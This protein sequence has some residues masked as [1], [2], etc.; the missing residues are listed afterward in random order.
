MVAPNGARKNKEDHSAIPLTIDELVSTA[1]A[2]FSAGADALHAHVRDENGKHSL[3]AG[4]YSELLVELNRSVPK[5]IIQITTEAVGQ[6]KPDQ[7]R[8]VVYKVNPQAVSV[9]VREMLADTDTKAIR[10][11]YH[12]A[13]EAKIDLQHILYSDED[14]HWL[15]KL[16]RQGLVPGSNLSLLFV[17]GRY[18][19]NLTSSPA[20]LSP[21]LTARKSSS[22]L[23]HSRFMVCAF[24]QHET[25]CLL[26]S[27]EYGGDCRIGFENNVINS[28]GTTAVSNEER[29]SSLA[30]LVKKPIN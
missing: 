29:V 10:N 13:S 27:V 4:L 20:D 21:F 26:A 2:C 5:M 8:E 25:D 24:G 15:D 3:D 9:A 7:Q 12:W 14:V 16:V 1:G 19:K 17:L 23:S 30:R 28:D 6:Y 11:F 22:H 18:T